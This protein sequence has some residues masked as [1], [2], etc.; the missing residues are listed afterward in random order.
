MMLSV[1]YSY[2]VLKI[3]KSRKESETAGGEV[4]ELVQYTRLA[5]ENRIHSQRS[6]PGFTPTA[7]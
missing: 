3:L 6:D 7:T 4:S 1:P 5:G 2:L